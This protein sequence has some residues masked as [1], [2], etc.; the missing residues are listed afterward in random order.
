MP[1]KH[2]LEKLR[3]EA[4]ARGGR[5]LSDS[6]EQK[7][8]WECDQG[9]EFHSSASS[10][11]TKNIW[12][13]KCSCKWKSEEICRAVFE[14]I[15]E[16]EFNKYYITDCDYHHLEL[17]GYSPE[18]LLAFEHQGVQHY[19]PTK[20]FNKKSSFEEISKRDDDKRTICK[21][22]N[23]CLVEIPQ[24]FQLT[25]IDDLIKVI[26]NQIN[27][28]IKWPDCDD[29]YI[30][31]Q[32]QI[33][34]CNR[35]KLCKRFLN[36]AKEVAKKNNGSCLSNSYVQA[37]QKMI[38]KCSRGHC[39]EASYSNVV[40]QNQWCPSCSN[41]KHWLSKDE[42]Q[43]LYFDQK[44]SLSKIRDKTNIPIKS[45]C[46]MAKHHNLILRKNKVKFTKEQL[47]DLYVEKKMS[48]QEI[49][50]EY[51]LSSTSVRRKL[52]K[53]NI[54]IRSNSEAAKRHLLSKEDLYAEYIVN[55]KSIK[56][57]AHKFECSGTTILKNLKKYN[58]EIKKSNKYN[59]LLKD[60]SEL[61][62]YQKKSISEIAAF[63]GCSRKTVEYHCK[64]HGLKTCR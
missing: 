13:P 29:K 53:H 10:V 57:I 33:L 11:I 23:I 24:L 58:I 1:R 48:S 6:Y 50:K 7:L 17:D 34:A 40:N 5:L 14:L 63:Y 9:H 4:E 16:R 41:R 31:K 44:L 12:C 51:D 36:R 27:K 55:N 62:I 37:D 20:I 35:N 59:I 28:N 26:K 30:I 25:H 46:D 47:Q 3:L 2:T 8:K 38:W 32:A 21:K 61:Y 18:L 60:L 56:E 39:W 15:F 64:K 54:P 19:E 22:L 43:S 52:I 45:L 42:F 49:G